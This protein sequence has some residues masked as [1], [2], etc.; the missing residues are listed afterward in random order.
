M[1]VGGPLTCSVYWIG[2]ALDEMGSGGCGGSD[3]MGGRDILERAMRRDGARGPRGRPR[4]DMTSKSP[5]PSV[6]TLPSS[7][8]TGAAVCVGFCRR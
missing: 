7:L 4:R 3:A 2:S 1:T 6:G 8:S 5:L